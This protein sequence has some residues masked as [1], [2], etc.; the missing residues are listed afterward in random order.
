MLRS[1]KEQ[2][3]GIV[4]VMGDATV[5]LSLALVSPL[6]QMNDSGA[7][8]SPLPLCFRCTNSFSIVGS[9]QG[10]WVKFSCMLAVIQDHICPGLQKSF[11]S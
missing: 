1:D 11:R 7:A 6:M 8:L 3:G 5:P 9:V 2:L 4:W 10:S